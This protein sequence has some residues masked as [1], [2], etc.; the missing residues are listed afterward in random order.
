[1]CNF[2]LRRTVGMI[3][4]GLLDD[5]GVGGAADGGR[6]RR[7]RAHRFQHAS[8][9]ACGSAVLTIAPDGSGESPGGHPECPGGLPQ[10]VDVVA[11]RSPAAARRTSPYT[12]P[13]DGEFVGFRPPSP[14]PDGSRFRLL[15][16]PT[17]HADVDRSAWHPQ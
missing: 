12:A 11:R 5:D 15:A 1:M 2:S 16:L 3:V 4:C 6:H 14:A 13:S 7:P 9:P 17:L 8:S 10:P